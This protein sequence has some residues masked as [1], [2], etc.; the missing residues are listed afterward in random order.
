MAQGR[1]L[2]VMGVSWALAASPLIAAAVFA[3]VAAHPSLPMVASAEVL[4]KVCY[5]TKTQM[6]MLTLWA[7]LR[8]LYAVL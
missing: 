6:H 5:C 3:G 7:I 4:R 2:K 8:T 1:L